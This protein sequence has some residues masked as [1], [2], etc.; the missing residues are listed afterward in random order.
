MQ[1]VAFIMHRVGLVT[2][3]EELD[4]CCEI[5]NPNNDVNQPTAPTPIWR[6]LIWTTACTQWVLTPVVD[7]TLTSDLFR[8]LSSRKERKVASFSAARLH[9]FLW[10][11][12]FIFVLS[13]LPECLTYEFTSFHSNATSHT[14]FRSTTAPPYSTYQ[15]ACRQE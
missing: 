5:N 14:D 8:R 2:Q 7:V 9:S 4:Y 6:L 11:L 12:S 13:P 15:P 1:C 10:R 3:G